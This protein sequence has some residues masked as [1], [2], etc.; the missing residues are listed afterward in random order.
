MKRRILICTEDWAGSG[1][2]M[3]AIALK[4]ALEER[5]PF[6]DVQMVGGLGIVS[7]LLEK[8][9]RM[10][11]QTSLRYAP[12][13]W[14]KL[15]S[16]ENMWGRALKR[17]LGK[18][19]A[20]RMVTRIINQFQPDTVVATH[21]YCLSALAEAKKA[22][23][24]PFVLASVPTD[25]YVNSFWVHPEVDFYV[26]AHEQLADQMCRKH[27]VSTDRVFPYGIPVRPGFAKGYEK[28]KSEWK[29]ELG[30]KAGMFTVLLTGGEGGYGQ[31]ADILQRLLQ[32]GRPLQILVVTGKNERLRQLVRQTVCT[33][34]S[35][36]VVHALGYVD[37]MWAYLGASDVVIGKPG[38]LTCT[39]AMA[40]GTPMLI[41]K[42]LPG[43]EQRN[44]RFLQEVGAAK[45]VQSLDEMARCINRWQLKKEEWQNTAKLIRKHGKPD[46]AFRFADFILSRI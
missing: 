37:S 45:E 25:F 33:D 26:V 7:P 31:L 14:E 44:S 36:H 28:E 18:V 24:V 20:K 39:E 17:P 3:A 2:K 13:V 27:Q 4:Q 34:P 30:F 35:P 19:L 38:G 21:A 8:I 40:M 15:Y 12:H 6:V 5:S 46:A 16:K 1:H 9:S 41:Y 23:R 43:Q 10:T 11:Y 42:P 32:S 29:M 22:V